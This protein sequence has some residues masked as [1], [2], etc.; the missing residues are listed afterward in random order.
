MEEKNITELKSLAIIQL[1]IDKSNQQLVDRSKYFFMWGF[2]VFC[3]AL[4]QYFILK[5]YLVTK[6]SEIVWLLMLVLAVIHIIMN[7]SDKKKTKVLSYD[8]N[9][10]G[11]LWLALGIIFVVLTIVA[12]KNKIEMLPFLIL[13][14]GIGNFVSRT[15]LQFKP[16]IYG[17]ISCFIL[18]I[19]VTYVNGP[20]T[21]V[22]LAL[23]VLLAYIIPA[24]ILKKEF[25]N[26]QI[27]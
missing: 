18:S 5:S 24:F 6:Y 15:I 25:K 10:I 14:Y 22:I 19:L 3:C 21:L 16:S 8:T 11:F 23:S 2:A 20:E 9:A 1:M 12:S 7:F 13:F 17:G 26:Q 27:K 4:I